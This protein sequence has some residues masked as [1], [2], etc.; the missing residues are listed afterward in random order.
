MKEPVCKTCGSKAHWTYQCWKNPRRRKYALKR[1]YSEYKAGKT[2]KRD[3]VL[4]K[5]TSERKRLILELDKYCSLITRISASDKF[6]VANCFTCG[7]RLPWKMLDCGHY[8]SRQYIGTR[9]DFDN[10]RPQCQECNRINRGNLEKYRFF[11][12]KEIGEKKVIALEAKK[13]KKITTPELEDLLK[14]VK[15]KYKK[16]VKEKKKLLVL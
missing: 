15:E 4:S 5:Q 1:K 9:F 12:E 16:I 13:L 6:G 8:K 10:V 3:K 7:K 11:L 2:P 14:E